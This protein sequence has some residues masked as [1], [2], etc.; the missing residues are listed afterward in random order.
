[1]KRKGIIL[2]ALL[3]GFCFGGLHLPDSAEAASKVKID[4]KHFPGGVFREYV[5][6][7][8]KNNDGY[9]SNKERDAVKRIDL[10]NGEFPH[11]EEISEAPIANMKGLGYFQQTEELNIEGYRLKNLEFGS[12]KKVQKIRLCRCR[13][14]DRK[15]SDGTYDFTKNKRLED[16]FLFQIG[17]I[18]DKIQ[19]AENNKIRKFDLRVP[20][21]L[22]KLDLR[23]LT[24]VEELG[25]TWGKVLES[26]DLRKCVRLKKADIGNNKKLKNLDFSNNPDLEE[27]MV[28]CNNKLK[29][30]NLSK[31]TKLKC[32]W[33]Y[34]NDLSD[35]D[36]SQN[37]ELQE[38]NCSHNLFETLDISMLKKLRDFECRGSKLKELDL[39]GNREL[40]SLDCRNNQLEILDLSMNKKLRSVD[41]SANPIGKLD[42]SMLLELDRLRCDYAMLADLDISQNKK[43]ASLSCRGN[44][45]S[46]MEWPESLKELQGTQWIDDMQ[47]TQL[48][49]LADGAVDDGISIDK[50]HFPDYALRYEVLADFDTNHDGVL[51]EKEA[52]AKRVLKLRKFDSSLRK[53]ID[54]TGMEYL[55]GITEV[56]VA[57]DTTLIN[58]IFQK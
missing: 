31:N 22:R 7:F 49:P 17:S 46:F 25:I 42:I 51:S 38:L 2:L 14:I 26:I 21:R 11:N 27:L 39:V 44:R 9:L 36:V 57:R 8:D 45:I 5:R 13:K 19:F 47:K 10:D 43:L 52:L 29:S 28:T 20:S 34:Y 56:M 37:K 32:L 1:M 3:A 24:Q 23:Q 12:L 40:E 58:N 4:K 18:V 6:S 16:V 50:E 53:E 41:C 15:K 35:L 33:I 54:C 48:L 30:M 55:K